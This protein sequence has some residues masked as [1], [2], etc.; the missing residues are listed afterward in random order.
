M[1]YRRF[2]RTEL[3]MPVLSCGGMRYQY[4]WQD[5]PFEEVEA[6]SHANLERTIARSLE[7][8]IN[9]IETARGYG[10]SERQ[11]GRILPAYPR[12]SLIVQTKIGP[13]ETAKEFRQHFE[14]SLE[15][16]RLGHVDLLAIHGINDRADLEKSIRPGGCLQAAREIQREGLAHHIGLSTHGPTD[17]LLE[18]IRHKSDGGFDYINLHWYYIFQKNWPAIEEATKRDMG[19]FIISPTD[20]GGMLFR[21]PDQLRDLTAPLHPIVFNDLFCLSR[22]EVHTLSVGAAKPEDF[23]LH[24]EAVELFDRREE[25]LPDIEERLRKRWLEVLG[26]DYGR[27]WDKGLPSWDNAPGGVNIP[28]ILWL[29]GLAKAYGMEEYGRMRYNLLGNA[30]AWF[31]GNPAEKVDELDLA[32]ALTDSPWKDRIPAL[33]KEAHDLLGGEKVKRLSQSE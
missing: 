9:H 15:R 1:L 29:L 20:K 10:S 18:A 13:T 16:L 23:D 12:E 17:L 22:P 25:F 21:P 26:E 2:G 8:G 7:F 31:P 33:L 6:A 19:V 14:E 27:S 24:V 32:P 3:R 28:V 4:K 30:G 11:L 5:V